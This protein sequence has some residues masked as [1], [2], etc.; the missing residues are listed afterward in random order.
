MRPVC[1]VL[2][3]LQGERDV[4]QRYLLLMLYVTTTNY[5][6]VHCVVARKTL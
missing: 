4:G 5:Y 6:S 3:K 2:D 1:H